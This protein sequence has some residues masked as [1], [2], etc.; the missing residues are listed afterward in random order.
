M[1]GQSRTLTVPLEPFLKERSRPQIMSMKQKRK[2]RSKQNKLNNEGA[3]SRSLY[4]SQRCTR[5]DKTSRRENSAGRRRDGKNR[6]KKWSQ[7]N[8]RRTHKRS[9]PLSPTYFFDQSRGRLF[10][11]EKCK[12]FDERNNSNRLP[13]S[14]YYNRHASYSQN[15]FNGTRKSRGKRK[16]RHK[17][18]NLQDRSQN[19]NIMVLISEKR[20]HF[21]GHREPWDHYCKIGSSNALSSLILKDTKGSKS[22]GYLKQKMA[23]K[24]MKPK[25]NT[26]CTSLQSKT[27]NVLLGVTEYTDMQILNPQTDVMTTSRRKINRLKKKKKPSKTLFYSDQIKTKRQEA[28][29][30]NSG[31]NFLIMCTNNSNR[32]KHRPLKIRKKEE[33]NIS[34]DNKAMLAN[35]GNQKAKLLKSLTMFSCLSKL[36]KSIDRKIIPQKQTTNSSTEFCFLGHLHS[37]SKVTEPALSRVPI[38]E[39]STDDSTEVSSPNSN[40]NNGDIKILP[41]DEQAQCLKITK[42]QNWHTLSDDRS[43]VLD[44]GDFSVGYKTTK[45]YALPDA[46]GRRDSISSLNSWSGSASDLGSWGV[47]EWW[48]DSCN[49]QERISRPTVKEQKYDDWNEDSSQKTVLSES[50]SKQQNTSAPDDDETRYITERIPTESNKNE[51][52]M[53]ASS[54]SERVV[55]SFRNDHSHSEINTP[56]QVSSSPESGLVI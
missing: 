19:C 53:V 25:L 21:R 3:Q 24:T 42:E 4:E 47:P 44:A 26:D 52:D 30:Q 29:N 1:S 13:Q 33:S 15:N 5:C 6:E 35:N 55:T 2:K 28:S 43:E 39:N 14:T 12:D 7:E 17:K 54:S 46:A 8:S 32:K 18:K 49:E 56:K 38:Q 45:R 51:F 36:D 50:M 23:L 40:R 34:F 41:Q 27:P 10:Q 31:K 20:S 48:Y 37:R 16:K 11:I 9:N 22:R